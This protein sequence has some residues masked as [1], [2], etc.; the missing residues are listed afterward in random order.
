MAL[1]LMDTFVPFVV[2]LAENLDDHDA[3]GEDL[4][5][6]A[7]CRVSTST[8][9]ST[10]R[11]REPGRFRRRV[12]LE[13]AAYRLLTATSTVLEVA[14]EAGTARTRR[15]PAHFAALTAPHRRLADH[16]GQIRLEAETAS[17]STHRGASGCPEDEV[18][19][20][21]LMTKMVENDVG[22]SAD[23]RVRRI[24]PRRASTGRSRCRSRASTTIRPCARSSRGSSARWTCGT[25][26]SEPRV[27]L[28]RRARREHRRRSARGW[29][30]VGPA[31]VAHAR[32]V[33]GAKRLDETFVDRSA[34]RRGLHLRRHAR[35]R[36]H[37]RGSSPHARDR[38][39]HSAGIHRPRRRRP[40][41]PG[42]RTGRIASIH[43]RGSGS[44]LGEP[45]LRGEDVLLGT[46]AI[47][48]ESMKS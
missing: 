5:A 26:H 27:R 7:I 2:S 18:S 14:V 8:V 4:A 21:D 20:M 23:R 37:L 45:T 44:G 30:M 12:L 10:H 39:H 41:A 31:F 33:I 6:R 16:A 25:R 3:A 11:R 34:S 28:R 40:D 47:E 9:P 24:F 1:Q 36:A 35:A 38:R 32:E 48:R 15:S 46:A 13:R 43:G 29:R 17:T 19:S 42:R 22:S